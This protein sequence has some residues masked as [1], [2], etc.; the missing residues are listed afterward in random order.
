MKPQ[1]VT[2]DDEARLDALLDAVT[3]TGTED[4]IRPWREIEDLATSDDEPDDPDPVPSKKALSRYRDKLAYLLDWSEED[5]PRDEAGQF[6]PVASLEGNLPAGEGQ[7][8][9]FDHAPDHSEERRL[10]M[11]AEKAVTTMDALADEAIRNADFESVAVEIDDWDQVPGAL[12]DEAERKWKDDALEDAANSDVGGEAG[13]E[14]IRQNMDMDDVAKE[15]LTDAKFQEIVAAHGVDTREELPYSTYRGVVELD[16]DDLVDANGEPLAA[17]AKIAVGKAFS[18]AA[19]DAEQSLRDGMRETDGYYQAVSDAESEYVNDGWNSLSDSDKIEIA[20]GTGKLAESL[21]TPGAPGTWKWDTDDPTDEDYLRTKAVGRELVNMRT[22]QLLEERGLTNANTTSA[23]AAALVPERVWEAWKESSTSPLGTALHMMVA[24]ELGTLPTPDD[25]TGV[26]GLSPVEKEGAKGAMIAAFVTRK[27]RDELLPSSSELVKRIEALPAA[28]QAAAW[29]RSETAD[30]EGKDRILALATGRAKAYVR[31]QWET[32][33]YLLKRAGTDHV[34]VLRA[35]ILPNEQLAGHAD[36]TRGLVEP[37]PLPTLKLLQNAVASTTTRPSV[38]NSWS[39]VGVRYDHA[40]N[41]R[42]VLRFRAPRT[43]VFSMPVYGENIQEESE[44]V[45]LGTKGLKWDAYLNRAPAFKDVPIKLAA[46][47]KPTTKPPP[48]PKPLIVDMNRNTKAHWLKKGWRKFKDPLVVRKPSREA[49]TLANRGAINLP[50]ITDVRF[51]EMIG[52]I[53]PVKPKK[54]RR[55]PVLYHGVK[56]GRAPTEFEVQVMSLT[57]IPIRLDAAVIGLLNGADLWETVQA[58]ADY[59]AREVCRELVRQGADATIL[60]APPAVDVSTC[61]AHLEHDRADEQ[62]AALAQIDRRLARTT[63]AGTRRER[64]VEHLLARGVLGATKRH[65]A[66]AVNEAFA[67]GRRRAIA[68][69]QRQP[70]DL[71]SRFD[72]L[73]SGKIWVDAVVQTAVMDT[74]TCD[75][76]SEVDGEVMELGE[77]R[78]EELHPPYVKC[79]GGDRCRCVQLALLSD[80]SEINVDEVPDEAQETLDDGEDDDF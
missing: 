75:E 58:M 5:H 65:A 64:V 55:K 29:A 60:D 78:Q 9:L 47:P 21:V 14:Y 46:D 73:K 1:N 4:E 69:Y 8:P 49:L 7:I 16:T 40:K 44:V 30:Q 72:K 28:E 17:D 36:L 80:G 63:L 50:D 24:E 6:S 11:A 42:V 26:R 27:E 20:K 77:D 61:V 62:A 32:T 12:Q 53:D 31:A 35:V 38:A 54:K 33:Q 10:E 18:R 51:P 22:T 37:Q 3:Y 2:P 76:C 66:R 41:R 68:T 71:A 48:P 56:L 23:V 15:A 45:L 25:P 19:E 39:G 34:E 57:D 13:E 79:L 43:A 70:L 59:G 52:A 67:L 74:N